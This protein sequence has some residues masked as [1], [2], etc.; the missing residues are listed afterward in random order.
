MA[1]WNTLRTIGRVFLTLFYSK[2]DAKLI[3]I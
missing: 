3:T 2:T 1:V